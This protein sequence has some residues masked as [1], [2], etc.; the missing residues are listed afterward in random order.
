[1]ELDARCTRDGVPILMHDP[2]TLRTTGTP[3]VVSWIASDTAG[4]LRL[5]QNREPV[6][7][8]SDALT[9]LPPGLGVAID[10]KDPAAGPAVVDNVRAASVESRVLLW[11]Q[12]MDVVRFTAGAAPD[13]ESSLLR[14]TRDPTRH[15]EFLD[16]AAEVGARGVSAHW[17]ALSPEFVDAATE[18]GLAVYS[19]C[20]RRAALSEKIAL[21]LAGIVTDW[22][23]D[24][25]RGNG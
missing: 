2:T 9:A 3:W 17:N 13:L 15:R 24:L 1:V 20:K 14:D 22:P 11:S 7:T 4:G 19:W 6:P 12:H 18:R 5:R 25:R 8:L 23:S 21:P 10:I 16:D